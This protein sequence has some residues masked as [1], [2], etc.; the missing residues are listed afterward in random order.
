M[1]MRILVTGVTGQVGGALASRLQPLATVVAADRSVLDLSR[2][3]EIASR[4]DEIAPGVIVNSAAYTQVDRAECER[5]LAFKVN[6]ASPGAMARWAARRRVPLVNLST[7]Y[8]FDG[9]GERPWQ[10]DDAPGPL[11]VYGES[12][13]AGET[14]IRH[15][16]GPHLIV[17]TS[18]I[19][20]ARGR[21]FLRAIADR[22][23]ECTELNVVADQVGAPTS[24]AIVADALVRILLRGGARLAEEFATA[25]SIVHVAANGFT[26]WHGFAIAIVDGLKARGAVVKTQRVVPIRSV[27]DPTSRAVRPR[28]SRLDVGRLAQVFGVMPPHW[29]AALEPEMD[30]LARSLNQGM[31]G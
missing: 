21:S 27:D 8:V 15:A 10:E 17:R 25:G 12:K 31:F 4:L 1:P 30:Q 26:S 7:D 16:G 3:G 24:A 22:A 2:P 19:Y 6:A 5:E 9:S 20:A 11:S 14:E 18:W 23:R 29:T 13:L 28:N